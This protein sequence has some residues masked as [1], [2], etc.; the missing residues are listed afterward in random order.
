MKLIKKLLN[1]IYTRE[2]ITL[3]I[4]FI[5]IF[6]IHQT[7]WL[8]IAKVM[9]DVI[10]MFISS[11]I[12]FIH[13]EK[14]YTYKQYGYKNGVANAI[15]GISFFI[16]LLSIGVLLSISCM[17]FMDTQPSYT[18][19]YVYT[20]V[21]VIKDSNEVSV[22]GKNIILKSDKISDYLS[23]DLKICKDE[24]YSAA[25]IRLSDKIYICK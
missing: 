22:I 6:G 17:Y 7:S 16:W 4:V 24:Q 2:V 12:V 10:I 3:F 1:M 25:K 19:H 23:N 5:A 8:F 15:S 11:L 14:R 20:P 21:S 13:G 18:K 9:L